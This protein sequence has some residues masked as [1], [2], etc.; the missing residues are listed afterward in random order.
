[1][2]VGEKFTGQESG[3]I[4]MYAEKVNDTQLTYIPLNTA[5]FSEGEVVDF[6]ESQVEAIITTI[7]EVSSNVSKG[8]TFNSGQKGTFYDYGT[9]KRRKETRQPTK[10]LKVYFSNGYYENSDDGDLTTKNSYNSMHYANDIQS[11]N[12]VRNTDII[13]IRPK[14][15]DYTVSEGARSPLEFYGRTFDGSGNSAANILKSDEQVILDFSFYLGRIDR[16]FMTKE[17]RFQIQYGEPSEKQ[18]EP[19]IID[20]AIEIATVDLAPYMLDVEGSTSLQFL[21]HKRYRMSDI[22]KLEERIKNL[23]YYTSLSVLETSTSNMFVPDASGN[24]RFKSGFF[25]DNFTTFQAQETG[26]GIKN[27]IDVQGRELRPQH[28]TNSIDLEL[29]PVEGVSATEDKAFIAPEGVNIKRSG[30]IITLDYTEVEWL[31]Q[32]F[33]TRSESIT[34]FLV[35]FWQM[36]MDITP[37]SD[38]WVDT[39]RMEAR[40]INIEGNYAQTMRDNPNVDPQTGMGPILWNSWE[41]VWTGQEVNTFTRTRNETVTSR[42]GSGRLIGDEK[43]FLDRGMKDNRQRSAHWHY[44][45]RGKKGSTIG[46]FANNGFFREWMAVAKASGIRNTQGPGNRS[47]QRLWLETTT[48][49][50]VEETVRDVVDTGTK[51]R[52]GTRTVITEQFDTTSQ[53]DRVVNREVIPI[54]RSRNVQFHAKKCKPLT[55]LYPFFDGVDVHKWCTP[56]LLE[57]K[58][59]SG[60]FQVGETVTSAVISPQSQW[61]KNIGDCRFRV[62]QANHREGPYNA[63]TEIFKDNPYICLLYTSDAADE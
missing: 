52:T 50:T 3:A 44:H 41:S 53:G 42:R 26:A 47:V 10:Q 45:N 7:D 22:K 9:I 51:T 20:D 33:A 59:T 35:S 16:I 48:N 58:M 61:R 49:R 17:G 56:K 57:I 1:M 15:S 30:D 6:E 23:E 36:S 28:Y 5:V 27:S 38:T 13:D 8:F 29:G 37:T 63:P 18:T 11:I 34:P 39:T 43:N 46:R 62:C 2:A 55:R 54:M 32:S 4:A 60:T 25:V 14:V 40:T 24:S 21:N 12:G 19:V 31:K